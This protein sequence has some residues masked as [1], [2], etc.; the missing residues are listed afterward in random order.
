[1]KF[2][3]DKQG[4]R[5]LKAKAQYGDRVRIASLANDVL[6]NIVERRGGEAAAFLSHADARKLAKEILKE[7]GE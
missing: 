2:K 6:I 4:E 1:M 3:A 7:I 5:V